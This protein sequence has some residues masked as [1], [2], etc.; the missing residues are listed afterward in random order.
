M[1]TLVGRMVL[2]AAVIVLAACDNGADSGRKPPLLDPIPEQ[3]APARLVRAV[4]WDTAFV[5]GGGAEDTLL[6]VPR[7][8]AG[9]FGRFAAFDYADNRIKTF[10]QNGTLLWIAGRTGGG[11]GE[12]EGNFGLQRS[13]GGTTWAADPNLSRLTAIDDTGALATVLSLRIER[14]AGVA[15][16]NDSPIII[17]SMSS[18]FL[19]ALDREGRPTAERAL[20]IPALEGLPD[21][22]RSV[23][24]ASDGG[25]IWA[26]A[27]PYGNVL[28]V[29]EG[30]DLRCSGKLVTGVGF[31]T[32]PVQTPTFSVSAIALRDTTVVVLANGGGELRLRHV[33]SYS[34]S[35]C[36]YIESWELPR[37]MSAMAINDD[38]F[39][40][41]FEDSTPVI[42]GLKM[43]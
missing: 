11:P 8:L 16:V 39:I 25:P 18:S 1:R 27:F 31:P 30:L 19:T 15:I 14:L 34:L 6:L 20:P 24:A 36:H 32:R 37:K 9:G 35:D 4:E 21:F 29:Y 43:K 28:L 23:I 17:S 13:R 40:F 41:E 2:A 7:T 10:D 12:F 5:V 38:T 33:D 26:I 42:I 22:A 3:P